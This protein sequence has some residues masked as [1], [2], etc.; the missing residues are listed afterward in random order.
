MAQEQRICSSP[1]IPG[2]DGLLPGKE[3]TKHPK[4]CEDGMVHLV[5]ELM[6]S[7]YATEFKPI[8]TR[9]NGYYQC[10]GQCS[11]YENQQEGSSLRSLTSAPGSAPSP[12]GSILK[13]TSPHISDI[14]II[15]M[16]LLQLYDKARF[17]SIG[18][19]RANFSGLQIYAQIS[20][21]TPY[22]PEDFPV[23]ESP[24][25]GG[26]KTVP[27]FQIKIVEIPRIAIR[28]PPTC[29]ILRTS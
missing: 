29:T 11:G 1:E 5:S 27:E 24:I 22:Q 28:S 6:D 9:N 2:R 14:Q 21:R 16:P 25:I 15:V 18:E 10:G 7:P 13:T 19:A 12:S 20:C 4:S 26:N 8:A 23:L 3:L 17:D